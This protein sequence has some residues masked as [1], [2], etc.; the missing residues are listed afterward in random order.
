MYLLPGGG[1]AKRGGG[2]LI[3]G[4]SMCPVR[5]ACT[6]VRS[7]VDRT[8][9][10]ASYPRW[11]VQKRNALYEAKTGFSLSGWTAQPDLQLQYFGAFKSGTHPTSPRLG[12]GC[13]VELR[14][15][16]YNCNLI[17][18][19]K[20]GTHLTMLL[21]SFQKK[22]FPS[23]FLTG[24][25]WFSGIEIKLILVIYPFVTTPAIAAMRPL[26]NWKENLFTIWYNTWC[27]G[28]Q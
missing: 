6:R 3:G 14:N 1:I 4:C 17:G 5:K 11:C 27:V 8:N 2:L 10:A 21:L 22:V 7:S 24:L 13:Q 9:N 26:P 15:L 20:S 28:N 25:C 18:A 19:F 12:F 16:T 23:G